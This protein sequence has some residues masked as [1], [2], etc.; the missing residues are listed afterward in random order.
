MYKQEVE[1]ETEGER[2]TQLSREK[3]RW[4]YMFAIL[5]YS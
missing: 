1:I 5:C 2:Q 4:G 3:G